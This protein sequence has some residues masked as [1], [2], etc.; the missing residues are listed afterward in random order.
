M[1]KKI[2]EMPHV[3]VVK[4]ESNGMMAC[5][6]INGTGGGVDLDFVLAGLLSGI[7]GA[8]APVGHHLVPLLIVIQQFIL[9]V[10][11]RRVD[12]IQA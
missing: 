2:Y 8:S 4:M 6:G 7:G 3:K 9:I 11:V 5:S 1:E 10:S 12:I